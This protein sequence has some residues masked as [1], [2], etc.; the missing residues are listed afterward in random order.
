MILAPQYFDYGLVQQEA[1]QREQAKQ[2]RAVVE[3]AL[4]K[5]YGPDPDP[6]VNDPSADCAGSG[7]SGRTER[8]VLR[9]LESW[10]AWISIGRSA[11]DRFA[12]HQ[13]KSMPT[14]TGI[15][16]LIETADTLG[17][18]AAG[19]ETNF[20]QVPEETVAGPSFDYALEKIYG[21][22][23]GSCGPAGPDALSRNDS[24]EHA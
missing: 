1:E 23:V 9:E 8:A 4:L 17:R 16:R 3:A 7:L 2:R 13:S 20:R 21:T 10:D 11:M 12:K 14:L 18:L 24:I 15:C 6:S 19:L 22:G 5:I